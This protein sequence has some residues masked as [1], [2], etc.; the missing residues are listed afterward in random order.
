MKDIIGKW[1]FIIGVLLAVILGF[2]GN[3]TSTVAIILVI[4]GLI[5]GLL[6]ITS[7]EATSFLWAGIALLIA[8]FW[9]QQVMA[10]VPA[11]ANVLEA[12]MILV[13]PAVIIVALREVFAMAK[14]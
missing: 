13:V 2:L 7:K 3:V 11:L 9:G 10:V 1:A 5:V 6:N 12:I 14:K 8:T 4:I